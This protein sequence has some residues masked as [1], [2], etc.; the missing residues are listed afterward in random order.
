M[1]YFLRT[2]IG[3]AR[4]RVNIAREMSAMAAVSSGGHVHGEKGMRKLR[5]NVFKY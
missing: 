4:L 1:K 5:M 2:V 3:V